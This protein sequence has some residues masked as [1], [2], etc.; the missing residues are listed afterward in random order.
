MENS[1]S[2]FRKA[3]AEGYRYI[4][5]DVHATAD[6]IVVVHHDPSLERVTDG[7]GAI[8]GLPWSAVGSARIA[9]REPVCRLDDVLEELPGAFLN[10][11]V[12]ADSA[13]RPVLRVLRRHNAWDRVCLAAFD[14]ARLRALRRDGDPSLLTSMGQRSAA[15]LW[16]GSRLAGWP[17]RGLVR[18]NAAQVPPRQGRLR[19]IDS[20][21]LRLAHRWGLEVHAWTIDEAAEMTALLDL[22]VDGLVTDRPD[23]LREVLRERGQWSVEPDVARSWES[24]EETT[25]RRGNGVLR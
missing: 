1:L 4:E 11:D 24:A 18:G 5:T 6:E 13:V 12:K 19:V 22:G 14:D 2:A 17:L 8:R 16:A 3:V 15:T 21:F 25:G 20:R 10:I 9:G 23:I 7:R